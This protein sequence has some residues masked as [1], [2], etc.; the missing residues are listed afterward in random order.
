M[1]SGFPDREVGPEVPLMGSLERLIYCVCF[2]RNLPGLCQR[3][4]QVREG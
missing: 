1:V 4:V 3:A 2:K